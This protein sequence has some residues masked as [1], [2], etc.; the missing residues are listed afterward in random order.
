MQS[1]SVGPIDGFKFF[2]MGSTYESDLSRQ[3]GNLTPSPLFCP[4]PG[5]IP[6]GGLIRPIFDRHGTK[7][8]PG[9][10]VR[11]ITGVPEPLN[12]RVHKASPG[13][14]PGE[15]TE[16]NFL[17]F[18]EILLAM[19]EKTEEGQEPEKPEKIFEFKRRDGLI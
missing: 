6:L 19:E 9:T 18:S 16:K 14:R 15:P 17:T 2:F 4:R 11:A 7:A 12:G 10:P 8:H 1:A 3:P 13:D 5:K